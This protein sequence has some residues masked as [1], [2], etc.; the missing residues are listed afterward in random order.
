MTAPADGAGTDSSGGGVPVTPVRVLVTHPR[1]VA[2]RRMPARAPTGE[3]DDQ[4]SSGDFLVRSLVRVQLALALRTI[5][6][7]GVLL[8]GLPLLFAVWP[9][10][11]H[12]H[13]LGMPLPWM[14]LGVLAY[15]VLI[16]L[17]ALH[18]R[19]AERNERSF[20]ALVDRQRP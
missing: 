13:V 6:A 7:L 2:P 5:V 4:T 15:P 18:V 10:S 16:A 12:I 3:I 9:G 20:I 11:A 1:T 8:G 19:A 14:L 17:G